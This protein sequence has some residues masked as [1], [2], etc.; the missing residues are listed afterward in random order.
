MTT[1]RD[2]AF[3]AFLTQLRA[4]D[5]DALYGTSPWASLAVVRALDAVAKQIVLRLVYCAPTTTTDGGGAHGIGADVLARWVMD[6]GDAR[7]ALE[8][9]M[10]RLMRL[11]DNSS[12]SQTS[13][14]FRFSCTS[15]TTNRSLNL[16]SS[17]SLTAAAT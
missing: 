15:F 11:R 10:A 14:T 5:L 17:S 12:C 8:R 7:G 2:G 3:V 4:R 1:V 13:S 6:T 16:K 9:A